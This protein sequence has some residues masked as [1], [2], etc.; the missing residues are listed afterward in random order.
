MH[1]SMT[2]RVAAARTQA[3][4][5]ALA[6]APHETPQPSIVTHVRDPRLDLRLVEHPVWLLPQP[7]QRRLG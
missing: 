4:G 7:P 6:Q 5:F 3:D 1:V 2:K